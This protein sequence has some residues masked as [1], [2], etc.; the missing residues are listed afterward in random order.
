MLHLASTSITW[1]TALLVLP[2][3]MLAY[4]Y[5]RVQKTQLEEKKHA[6]DMAALHLRAIEGLALAVEAKDNLNTR[7]HLRR[8]QVYALGVGKAMGL[9]P[10]ELEA[11]HAAALL[12]DIGKLAVPEHILTKPGK[13]SPEEFAKMKVHPLVGA[14]IVEQVKFPY[15]VAPIVRAHHEK[16]DGSGY[17]LGLKGEEIPLGARILTAVDCLDALT[18]DREYRKA[19]PSEEAMNRIARMWAKPLTAE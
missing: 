16:W 14:E 2:V 12:H 9:G 17:P 4:R 13:L 10:I 15:E 18:S 11:L 6:G 8:V 7:G 3:I 19:L 5:Y 1:D